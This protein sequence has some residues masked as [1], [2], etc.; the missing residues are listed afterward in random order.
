MGFQQVSQRGSH[1]KLRRQTPE[2]A[3]T[4]IVKM[5]A[6][7]IPAGTLASILRQAGL[8]RDEFEAA[9]GG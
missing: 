7:E 5:G 4:V 9:V 3:H 6:R 8:S 2:R 1:L